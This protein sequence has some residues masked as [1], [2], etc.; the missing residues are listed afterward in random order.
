LPPLQCSS[1]VFKQTRYTPFTKDLENNDC[2]Y[3]YKHQ[4]W[5]Y[6]Q[7]LPSMQ[8][9]NWHIT[10]RSHIYPLYIYAMKNKENVIELQARYTI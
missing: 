3:I 2:H 6:K 10:F 9:N 5:N 8:C 1:L 4:I 7:V